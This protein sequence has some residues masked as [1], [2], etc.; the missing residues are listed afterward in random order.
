VLD[1]ERRLDL[2]IYPERQYRA[3]IVGELKRMR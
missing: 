3:E 1:E 2:E